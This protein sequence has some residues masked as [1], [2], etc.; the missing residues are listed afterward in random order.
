L[1]IIQGRGSA[2]Q[3]K[4]PHSSGEEAQTSEMI[5]MTPIGLLEILPSQPHTA[6]VVPL[7]Y[8]DWY[9]IVMLAHA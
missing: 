5:V 7:F 3:K 1:K 6:T 4:K 2:Y 9:R 8:D